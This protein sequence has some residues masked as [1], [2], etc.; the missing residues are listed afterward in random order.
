M[1]MTLQQLADAIHTAFQGDGSLEITGCAGLEE[2]GP[3]EVSFLANRRYEELA[4]ATKAGAL[5]VSPR[6]AEAYA[7][8]N[9]LVAEDPYFAFR[10]A[11]VALHG[12]RQHP[13]PGISP[14]AFI[15]PSAE[16][17]ELCT[18]RPFVYIA[19]G[20][21]VGRRVII[22]PGCY[23]GKGAEIGDDCLLY[24]SVTVYDGCVLGKRVTLH[25]GCV[26]GQDGFGYAT[27]NGVHHKIPQV[28]NVVIENDVE[29]GAGCVVDRATVG[30]T[31][32]REGT[33]FSDLVAIGHG[34]RVGNLTHAEGNRG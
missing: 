33:K 29:M 14:Q 17:S 16:L 21:K 11:V 2:A 30:S 28:G 4:R 13:Q 20:A 15:D 25:A 19:P 31:V 9:L 1:P 6:A 32:I 10:E 12:W 23:I 7:G 22:Y 8:R 3:H 24:P 27:H 26:I 18:I 34:T 5:V